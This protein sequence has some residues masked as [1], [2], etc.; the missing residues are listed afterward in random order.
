MLL[1]RE[2]ILRLLGLEKLDERLV[3]TPI[4]DVDRQVGAGSIDLRLGSEF[5]ETRRRQA[6]VVD[7]FESRDMVGTTDHD[8]YDVPLG[9]SL[10]VHPGQFL[11]GATFEFIKL[12]AAL[13][14]QVLGRSSWGRFGLV[15][16][17]AVVV[18]PGY[19]G[20]LTLELQNVG[21]VP[22]RL[23]P[24]LRIAQLMLWRTVEPA[25]VPYG[26]DAKYQ[27]PLGPETSRIGWEQ[28]EVD[29]LRSIGRKLQGTVANE[30][31]FDDT[32]QS[33]ESSSQ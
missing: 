12:P 18:Q 33:E 19:G 1:Q 9:E 5:I 22:M 16:A 13:G 31:S 26:D 24:G 3:V 30:L 7:P 11:L 8:R 20:C 6:E 29:R 32:S 2:E 4:L 28:G 25:V 17:T 14:G 10:I 21:S 27:V 23:Y 15:V